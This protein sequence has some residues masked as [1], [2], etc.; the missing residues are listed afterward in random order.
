MWMTHDYFK[1]I[2]CRHPF[3][4]ST[5]VTTDLWI[6]VPNWNETEREDGRSIEQQGQTKQIKTS[7]YWHPIARLIESQFDLC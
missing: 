4:M 7:T 2:F 6:V 1:S 3:C 5:S